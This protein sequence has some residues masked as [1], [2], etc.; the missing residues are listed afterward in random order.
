MDYSIKKSTVVPYRDAKWRIVKDAYVVLYKI[1]EEEDLVDSDAPSQD[2]LEYFEKLLTKAGYDVEI[3][4]S[5][6]I[7]T[8]TGN[9]VKSSMLVDKGYGGS[10]YHIIINGHLPHFEHGQNNPLALRKP[11]VGDCVKVIKHKRDL[12]KI[13]SPEFLNNGIPPI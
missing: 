2:Y 9:Q 5:T 8:K 4:T 12:Q 3:Q 7:D 6:Y 1:V 13:D 10:F 11:K